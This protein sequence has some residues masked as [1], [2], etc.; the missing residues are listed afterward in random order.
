MLFSACDCLGAYRR[1]FVRSQQA[2]IPH[3]DGLECQPQP[4]QEEVDLAEQ[5]GCRGMS[6]QGDIARQKLMLRIFFLYAFDSTMKTE[7]VKPRPGPLNR[8]NGRSALSRSQF[9][10]ASRP[11]TERADCEP[12]LREV[13]RLFRI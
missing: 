12:K 1:R 6:A 13:F 2:A 9:W 10:C 4:F 7:L 5:W 8:P 3:C 11:K